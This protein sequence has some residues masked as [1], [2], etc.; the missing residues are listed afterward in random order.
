MAIPTSFGAS[1][2]VAN[3]T[4]SFP[5]TG[6]GIVGFDDGGTLSPKLIQLAA[7]VTVVVAATTT[8]AAIAAAMQA[9]LRQM[10]YNPDGAA[11]GYPAQGTKQYAATLTLCT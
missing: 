2:P 1:T 6:T 11:G 5:I 10:G 9:W 8:D 7:N 3:T 4:K